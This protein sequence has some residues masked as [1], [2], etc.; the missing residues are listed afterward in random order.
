MG[1]VVERSRIKAQ[2]E[3]RPS[4]VPSRYQRKVTILMLLLVDTFAFGMGVGAGR[5]MSHR[6][7]DLPGGQFFGSSFVAVWLT[8]VA[9][10]AIYWSY[11]LYSA[12]QL[13]SGGSDY[14][15]VGNANAVGVVAAIL[16]TG[17]ITGWTLDA[18]TIVPFWFCAT[19][20]TLGGRF[21]MRRFIY[22]ETKKGRPVERTLIL[23]ANSEGVAIANQLAQ[24]AQTGSRVIAFLDDFKTVGDEPTPGVPILGPLDTLEAA[25]AE[26]AIDSVLIASP[27]VLKEFFDR[28]ERALEIL[29]Q[30][31]VQMAW[32]GFDL[33]TTG[34]RVK[35]EGSVPLVV[36]NKTRIRGL[37]ALLKAILDLSVA[38]LALVILFPLFILLAFLVWREDRAAPFHKRGVVGVNGRRFYAY[39]FR[40][41]YPNADAMLT[42]EMREEW[43]VHGKIQSDPRITK[44]GRILRKLSLDELPQLVNVLRGEMSLVGPRMITPSEL[45]RFGRW[46]HSRNLVKP[47]MTGLWQVSGRSDLSYEDRARLDIHYIRNHSIWLDL[48]ILVL[49]I[50]AVLSRR[51]AS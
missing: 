8:L 49:T 41:M 3:L 19:L 18:R 28:E 6:V 25:I 23:G 22:N 40:T 14:R 10:L 27:K 11:G 35:E 38:A 12:A 45:Q 15:S 4:A 1:K 21:V 24:S 34:V 5:W 7:F 32:G 2:G 50:P 33:L 51:G 47:G 31:E 13:S 42:P 17:A 36:L 37:H 44:I 26:H 46:Q 39:K 48:R 30:V 16:I 29:S 9:Y 43:R 20:F